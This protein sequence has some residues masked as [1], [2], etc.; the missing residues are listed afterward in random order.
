MV[1]DLKRSGRRGGGGFYDYTAEGKTLWPALSQHFPLAPQQ[2]DVE[3][4]RKRLLYIQALE[5]ARCVEAGVVM[6]P[7]DADLGA[8][9]G[10]GFPAWTGGTLSFIDTLGLPTFV[11][12]CERLAAQYGPRFKTSA[13]LK[14]K[15][16]NGETFHPP[17]SA[18]A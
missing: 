12:E 11:A 17:L 6:E 5:T 13:W 8:I 14:A 2:P 10:I 4:A 7:A 1:R 3:E 15:A 18:A 9:L 16:H